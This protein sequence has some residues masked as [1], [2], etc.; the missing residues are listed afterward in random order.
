MAPDHRGDAAVRPVDGVL[1]PAVLHGRRRRPVRAEPVRVRRPGDG[2]HPRL[3]HQVGHRAC[4]PSLFAKVPIAILLALSVSLFAN[5]AH[6]GTRPELRQRRRRPDPRPRR[7]AVP[8][9]RVR[10]VLLHGHRRDPARG[11]QP[12]TPRRPW[13]APTTAPRWAAPAING[14]KSVASRLH[15]TPPDAPLRPP[16][17]DSRVRT[18]AGH[19]A[20]SARP[21]PQ[22]PATPATPSTPPSPSTVGPTPCPPRCGGAPGARPVARP[23][24]PARRVRSRAPQRARDRGRGAAGGAAAGGAAGTAGAAGA[25]TAGVGARSS[26]P[27]PRRP[28]RPRRTIKHGVDALRRS[29][30]HATERRAAGTVRASPAPPPET[31]HPSP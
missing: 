31:H 6:A 17:P 30:V 29:R 12:S 13:A 27:A 21:R 5:S 22:A 15:G 20:A 14:A 11:A 18:C 25:A 9:A 1:R 16:R 10:P 2:P 23:R 8:A 7:P 24:A 19:R 4:S 26:W 28:A 3:V